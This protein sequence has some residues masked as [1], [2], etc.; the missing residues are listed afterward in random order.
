MG[1]VAKIK[2]CSSTFC[3]YL[4]W[5][6][7]HVPWAGECGHQN[8]GNP[9]C[10]HLSPLSSPAES[11]QKSGA[12]LQAEIS[13]RSKNWYLWMLYYDILHYIVHIST[14]CAYAL[15][16]FRHRSRCRFL[17]PSAHQLSFR[18]SGHNSL[19]SLLW[20]QR[21]LQRNWNTKTFIS[22]KL[23]HVQLIINKLTAPGA[24]GSWPRPLPLDLALARPVILTLLHNASCIMLYTSS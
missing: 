13:K 7:L 10:A 8:H 12:S 4:F 20:Y 3:C 11:L 1:N 22:I 23:H 14:W 16:F 15:T 5:T 19:R 21:L 24:A 2:P 6:P 9:A 18:W 17:S